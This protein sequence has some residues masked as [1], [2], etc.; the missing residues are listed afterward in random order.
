MLPRKILRIYSNRFHIIAPILHKRK[1]RTFPL[2]DSL[3]PLVFLQKLF[4]L[5]YVILVLIFCL[6]ELVKVI[7]AQALSTHFSYTATL[8]HEPVINHDPH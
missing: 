2:V 8:I 4:E 3:F 6:N 7:F 1:E 5:F